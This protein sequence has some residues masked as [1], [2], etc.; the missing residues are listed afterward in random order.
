MLRVSAGTIM[1]G[2]VACL[3]V[4]ALVAFLIY[5]FTLPR[6]RNQ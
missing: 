1:L 3:F 2:A 4:V 6:N 5:I